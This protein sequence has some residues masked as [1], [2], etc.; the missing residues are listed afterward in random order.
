MEDDGQ[1]MSLPWTSKA[2]KEK[3]DRHGQG[4]VPPA[5]TRPLTFSRLNQQKKMQIF[6]VRLC[7]NLFPPAHLQQ[8]FF[9]FCS[10]ANLFFN[11]F[12]Q[13]AV[14]PRCDWPCDAC[15]RNRWFSTA[16]FHHGSTARHYLQRS[17]QAEP[18]AF[19]EIRKNPGAFAD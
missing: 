10:S 17:G 12:L 18:P 3:F 1:E 6:Q 19:K 8:H 14:G 15:D 2:K 13:P 4:W 7:A 5:S 11:R 9:F 16:G